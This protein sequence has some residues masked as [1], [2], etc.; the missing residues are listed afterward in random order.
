MPDPLPTPPGASRA[1]AARSAALPLRRRAVLV[2]TAAALGSPAIGSA[3]PAAGP[4]PPGLLVVH[5]PSLAASAAFAAAWRPSRLEASDLARLLYGDLAQRWHQPQALLAGLTDPALAF[6]LERVAF[7]QGWRT[8][9]R[10]PAP[11]GTTAASLAQSARQVL[12]TPQHW[13]ALALHAAHPS[14]TSPQAWL[15]APRSRLAA[16]RT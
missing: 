8:V 16:P 2:G 6:C 13:R 9:W 1:G 5:Q 12:G 15:M 14:P 10:Q 3:R 7:E 11:D 4:L